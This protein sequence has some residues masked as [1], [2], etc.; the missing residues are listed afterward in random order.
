MYAYNILCVSVLQSVSANVIW[1]VEN[2]YFYLALL[3]R[4]TKT[5]TE[6]RAP[7]ELNI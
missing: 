5:K 2:Y 6:E 3:Q 4:L 1:I 7:T